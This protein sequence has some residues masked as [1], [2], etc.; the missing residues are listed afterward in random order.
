MAGKAPV[1]INQSLQTF[2]TTRAKRKPPYQD[3]TTVFGMVE[4]GGKARTMKVP[5]A[6]GTTLQPIMKRM[7][8]LGRSRL[9]TDGHGAYRLIK[10]YLRH[11]VIDHELAYVRGDVHTQNIEGYWSI[12]KRG[13][14]G[15]FHHVGD[16]Y[17]PQYLSEF[18]FR[19]NRRK[20]S[21]VERFAA[22]MSQ[23]QGRILW[24]C[25]TPQPLNPHA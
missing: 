6:R 7:I 2:R 13:V 23:T 24:Y 25:Q 16:V 17:L 3:K 14:Y 18:E 19:F 1:P 10:D 22:L 21:D 11:D 9:I 8:D 20:I 12:L 4:R 5:D 15:V